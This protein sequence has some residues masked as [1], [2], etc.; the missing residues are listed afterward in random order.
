[1]SSTFTYPSGGITFQS[2]F[3][4]GQKRL[5]LGFCAFWLFIALLELGQDYLSTM[6]NGN[7]FM[8]GESLSYKL[9]WLL[10]IPFSLVLIYG[11]K[12]AENLVSG[13]LLYITG[14]LIVSA[15]TIIHL[16][17]FSVILFGI[18]N[19]IH[20]EPLTLVF[21]IYEK[22]STRL[23]MALSIYFMLSVLYVMFKN[24]RSEQDQKSGQQTYSSTL[25]VK[26]GRRTVLVEVTDIRWIGSDGAYLDIHTES[27]KH[28]I[29][30]SL[31]DIINRLPDNFKRIH[32]S[33]IV[34]IDHISELKSRGNGD[35]DVIMKDGSV[36]RLSR[37]YSKAL[38]G[39]FL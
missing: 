31:K 7:A 1:M 18:S 27:K 13:P 34:N 9:F 5:F 16:T 19:L 14:F 3:N 22:L 24:R 26:N 39:L 21:L 37:N 6:L 32:K 12:K 15:S 8:I 10:F 36:L 11:Y 30:D 38:K 4:K 29:L 2:P 28:V 23:Y 17:V 33:T 35:Y 25:T 20:E